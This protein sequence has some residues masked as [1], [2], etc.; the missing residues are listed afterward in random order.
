MPQ[1]LLGWLV[2]SKQFAEYRVKGFIAEVRRALRQI[3]HR[4]VRFETQEPLSGG[5]QVVQG[6]VAIE[7]VRRAGL[8]QCRRFVRLFRFFR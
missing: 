6:L 5:A 1:F 3:T 2:M 7:L 8:G 4:A